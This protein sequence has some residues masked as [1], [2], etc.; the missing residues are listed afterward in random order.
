MTHV[1]TLVVKATMRIWRNAP[2]QVVLFFL[3]LVWIGYFGIT[4]SESIDALQQARSHGDSVAELFEENTDRIFERVDQS[5]LV[6]RALYTQDPIGFNLKIWADRARIASGDVVQFSLIG[7]DGYMLASTTGYS[8]P[9]LY[10][11]DREHFINVVRQPEDKLYVAKPVLGR[12]SKKWTIQIARQVFDLH[13]NPAGVIVGSI[14]VDL[15]GRFYD[16][17]KLGAGGTLVLRNADYVVLAARGIDQDTLLGQR[18]PGRVATQLEGSSY[19]Q[20]WSEGRPDRSNRLITARKS[21]LFP[22]ILTVG[23]SEQEIYSRAQSRQIVYFG[24]AL[25]LT[26]IIVAATAFHWRRKRALDRAQRELR[27]SLGKFE[28]ASRELEEVNHRLEIALSNMPNGL[29]LFDAQHRL[30]ISNER[31]QKMYALP[32]EVVRPGTT[33]RAILEA[34]LANGETS[35]LDI[36]GFVKAC[37]RQPTQAHLLQDGRTVFIRRKRI[38]EG[39]WIATHEDITELKR[40]QDELT[41]NAAELQQMNQR[42]DAA[43]NSMSHGICLYD[44]EQKVVVSNSRYAEIYKLSPQQV[45]PGTSLRQVLEYRHQQGT[46]FAISPEHYVQVNVKQSSETQALADGRIVSIVRRILPEGGWLTTHEDITDRAAS[47]RKIAYLAEHD[48]LTGLPNRAFFTKFLEGAVCGRGETS[49]DSFALLL[50]DLDKFKYVNDTLGHPAG[51]QLLIQVASRLKGTLLECDVLARLGGDEFAIIQPLDKPECERAISLAIRVIDTICQPFDI[52][53]H[54][55]QIGTSIGISY[56][57]EDG[58]DPKDLLKKADLALY[59]AKSDGRNDYRLYQPEMMKV[60]EVQKAVE[61]ELR[62]AILHQE[63]ELFYQPIVEMNGQTV[64]IAEALVRWRHPQRGLVGPNEFIPVAESTGLIVP[65]G[66]W[67]LQQACNDAAGWPADMRVAVNVSAVQFKKGNLF[68]IVLCALVQSGL[69]P[70]RLEIEITESAL[71]EAEAS[72]L[73]TIRQLKNI[74]VTIALDDFGTGYSSAAYATK[75]PL[76]KL[77]IDKSFIQGAAKTKS[78]AAVVASALA[79]ARGLDLAV[80]AEGVETEEQLEMLRQ[81]GVELAQGYYFARPMSLSHFMAGQSASPS[82]AGES[83]IPHERKSS[84]P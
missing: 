42:F 44:A 10:L 78:C 63:F 34:H 29:C 21:R 20:Y 65:L 52:D 76:D 4:S 14:S 59:A 40:I 5:L 3:P 70:D 33:L 25:L 2:L 35:E 58:R 67:I 61:N 54:Q 56:A 39:G 8:G 38:A 57:P 73:Q 79:L 23:I 60:A 37:L 13:H 43:I 62:E 19:S 6:V 72:H 80:T 55:V 74:G 49:L 12:A 27:D 30:V 64:H 84:G 15:M 69:S 1:R 81:L 51:D 22:L 24:C 47:E 18:A 53:G 32:D 11:G 31:Y 83:R 26:L 9:Q 45:S 48:L 28:D 71:L 7:P 82:P 16:T 36:D 77:K 50:L 17:A 66:E 68:D 46:N 75:V 41:K